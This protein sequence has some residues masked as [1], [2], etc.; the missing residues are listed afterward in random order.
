MSDGKHV[1]EGKECRPGTVRK[2][3]PGPVMW[4]LERHEL[5]EVVCSAFWSL[6]RHL[7]GAVWLQGRRPAGGAQGGQRQRQTAALARQHRSRE[8]PLLKTG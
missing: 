4:L 3:I 7:A 5:A 6:A 8:M 1:F 2:L